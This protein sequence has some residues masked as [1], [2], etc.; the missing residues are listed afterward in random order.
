[1]VSK[2]SRNKRRFKQESELLYD[3]RTRGSRK[4]SQKSA[5]KKRRR[6]HK[7]RKKV[8]IDKST[9][10]S[11][12]S[13]SFDLGFSLD[14]SSPS[15]ESPLTKD[16][17]NLLFSMIIRKDKD[18]DRKLQKIRKRHQA[19]LKKRESAKRKLDPFKSPRRN[20]YTKLTLAFRPLTFFEFRLLK[21]YKLPVQKVEGIRNIPGKLKDL[22]ILMDKSK[23]SDS[24]FKGSKE[25]KKPSVFDIYTLKQEDYKKFPGIFN[26]EAKRQQRKFNDYR[27]KA[28][29]IQPGFFRDS[30]PQQMVL[31]SGKFF[32]DFYSLYF[33]WGGENV[34]KFGDLWSAL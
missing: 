21:L 16:D 12:S 27:R 10:E 17:I 31:S 3:R 2:D 18:E 20:S 4:V 13:D 25:K 8:E 5:P 33:L 19:T 26:R 24:M 9:K 30:G 34:I 15:P 29:K 28:N 14:S 7:K 6:K 23:L 1:M 32:N 22:E 11:S